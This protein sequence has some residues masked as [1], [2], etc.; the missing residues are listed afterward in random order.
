[1]LD[2][3]R[4][5]RSV[6]FALSAQL[7]L[8]DSQVAVA[9][10]FDL[11]GQD[12]AISFT[13]QNLTWD[14]I[15]AIYNHFHPDQQDKLVKPEVSLNVQSATIAFSRLKGFLFD[16]YGLTLGDYLGASATLAIGPEG[17]LLQMQVTGKGLE[18]GGCT[19]RDACIT[20]TVGRS[21]AL[22]KPEFRGSSSSSKR[23]WSLG[24]HGDLTWKGVD[25]I[26]AGRLY[27]TP[28]ASGMQYTLACT[29]HSDEVDGFAIGDHIPGWENTILADIRFKTVGLYIASLEESDAEMLKCVPL[30][31]QLK[32][33]KTACL[34]DICLPLTDVQDFNSL[35]RL[36]RPSVSAMHLGARTWVQFSHSPTQVE[37]ERAS[38]QLL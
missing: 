36:A 23:F 13:I 4:G 1:M 35:P 18:L 9:G 14:T 17:G 21:K 27:T 37:A 24:I 6:T 3:D 29:L 22:V 28:D 12:F 33:G 8:I 34:N 25:F 10:S 38:S 16:L 15:I 19:I 32:P 7:S 5:W 30:G 2:T 26:V 11:A 20:L 31:Y